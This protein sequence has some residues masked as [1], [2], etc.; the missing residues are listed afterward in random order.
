MKKISDSTIKRLSKYYRSLEHL[1]EK[2]VETVSSEEL[3]EMDG[4]TSAQVRKDLSFF[5]TFGKRGLGY[6]TRALKDQ[7]AEILGLN[8]RWNVAI[9]GAGNIGRALVAYE[10]FR[11]QGFDIKLIMDSDPQKIGNQIH[12]LPIEDVNRAP[13][14]IARE[15]IDIAI[16]AVPANA[17]QQVADM[18]VD[19]GV[20][21]ILN[22][23]PR[24]LKVPPHVH[25]KNENMAIEIEALSYHLS[26]R[27]RGNS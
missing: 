10:E 24:S 25:I 17:A 27:N 11:K 21:A 9:V 23:A 7:I 2:G 8:R 20:K 3:A 14:L 15:R 13:E 18:L 22:F 16:I 12:G 6:N 5:G 26:N 1:I 4:I 19:A